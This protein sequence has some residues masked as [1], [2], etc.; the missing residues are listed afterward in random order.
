MRNFVRI[1]MMVVMAILL[2]I[3]STLAFDG[4][5]GTTAA[6]K[7]FT[8]DCSNLRN[9]I[10]D[11]LKIQNCTMFE[12]CITN[13]TMLLESLPPD[14]SHL[15][16][17]RT[18]GN[19]ISEVPTDYL[20]SS[21]I[22]ATVYIKSAKFEGYDIIVDG[23]YFGTEGKGDDILDGVYIFNVTGNQ[24]HSVRIDHPLNWKSWKIFYNPGEK[25]T[26]FF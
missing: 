13:C 25:Y 24:Q 14:I 9:C 26:V 2:V 22:N 6:T 15:Q 11:C 5:D 10:V 16:D 23:K 3:A 17:D 7:A 19:A 8:Q 1:G 20:E 21:R 18:D 12:N 4:N